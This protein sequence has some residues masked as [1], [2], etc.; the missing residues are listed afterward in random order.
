MAS[1]LHA[2]ISWKCVTTDRD[3]SDMCGASSNTSRATPGPSLVCTAT[4]VIMTSCPIGASRRPQLRIRKHLNYTCL[5][6]DSCRDTWNQTR[7]DVSIFKLREI[8]RIISPN[9]FPIPAD[10]R[11]DR[12]STD[13]I[14]QIC[15]AQGLDACACNP[16]PSSWHHYGTQVVL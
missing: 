7:R 11:A 8:H 15:K 1:S 4:L 3:A 14:C 2:L 6:Q 9:Y 12:Y 16:K 5:E 13:N 10:S